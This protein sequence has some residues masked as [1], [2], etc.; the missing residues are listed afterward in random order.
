[1]KWQGW[2]RKWSWSIL[3]Y[4]Q[5]IFLKEM[6][7]KKPLIIKIDIR[8]EIRTRDLPNMEECQDLQS[9]FQWKRLWGNCSNAWISS[10]LTTLVQLQIYTASNK[11]VVRQDSGTALLIQSRHYP[12]ETEE[13]YASPKS[14]QT[15]IR[16]RYDGG[17]KHQ[18][19]KS[20]ASSWWLRPRTSLRLKNGTD[21]DKTFP[22]TQFIP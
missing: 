12:A 5:S 10:D 2:W 18:S 13:N 9:C 20:A 4:Y 1:M 14:L 16:S 17:S 6:N 7:T 3:K 21:C 15:I 8:A 11:M 22:A 19:G